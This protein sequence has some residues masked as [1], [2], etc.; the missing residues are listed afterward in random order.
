MH[1][2]QP[3]TQIVRPCPEREQCLFYH[4]VDQSAGHEAI[5]GTW[6]LRPSVDAYLG[7]VDLAGRSVLEIG[8]ASGFLSFHME[9]QGAEVTTLEPPMKHLWDVVPL[10]GFDVEGWRMQFKENIVGVRNSFWYLHHL[11]RSSVRMIEANPEAIPQELG[12]FD[13]GVLAAV[14]LHCR[15][16]FSLIES[17]SRRVSK[18]MIIT[19]L[20]DA[21][22][23]EEPLCKLIPRPTIRQVDTWWSFSPAF[24]VNAL[25]V[26][27]FEQAQ[28]SIHHQIHSEIPEPVPMFTVVA[29]RS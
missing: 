27:G 17:L 19:D 12:S 18:T 20:Y 6:D 5:H 22:L 11:N 15:S 16:P 10:S 29:Q 7:H 4:S 9:K 21:T 26:L 8:P 25:G 1:D 2:E 24:I 23:G 13:I 28:V 14:L 3:Y